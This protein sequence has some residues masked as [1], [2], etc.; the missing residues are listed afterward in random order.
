MKKTPV[1]SMASATISSA[2]TFTS[3]Q[4]IGLDLLI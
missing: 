3:S 1:A 4:V 2:P